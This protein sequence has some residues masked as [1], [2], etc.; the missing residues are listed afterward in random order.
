MEGYSEL[1]ERALRV[2]AIAHRDQDRKGSNVPYITH[3]VQVSLILLSHGFPSDL[4]IAGLLHDVVEDQEYPLSQ[5][6]AAFG[7]RVAEIV[8][9]LSEDKKD[10]RGNKRPWEVRKREALEHMRRAD[11]DVAAVKA[12]DTLHNIRCILLD[13]RQEGTEVWERFTRGPNLMLSYYRQIAQVAREH[14]GDHPL[15]DELADA[16][17]DLA[18]IEFRLPSNSE[19]GGPGR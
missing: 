10:V 12:A 18:T 3:P 16:I 5:I 9:A 15:V 2:A 6:E 1:Y 7:P 11:Q 4:A 19:M 13:A 8:A 17:E 14:L